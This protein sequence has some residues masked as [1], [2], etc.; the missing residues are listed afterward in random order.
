[1]VDA[2]QANATLNAPRI[3]EGLNL[4]STQK[5]KWALAIADLYLRLLAQLA[6]WSWFCTSGPGLASLLCLAVHGQL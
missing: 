2:Q 6:C 4:T 3:I 1:M 5:I